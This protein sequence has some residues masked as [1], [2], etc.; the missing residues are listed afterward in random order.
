[1]NIKKYLKATANKG[2]SSSNF[3]KST[4]LIKMVAS[5]QRLPGSMK[6]W[7]NLQISW[8]FVQSKPASAEKLI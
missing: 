7:L 5:F 4:V 8:L 3:G 2:L 1:M 6:H